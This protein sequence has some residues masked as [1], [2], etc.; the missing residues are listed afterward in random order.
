MTAADQSTLGRPPLVRG[1][2]SLFSLHPPLPVSPCPRLQPRS[3]AS[4][5]YRLRARRVAGY[6]PTMTFPVGLRISMRSAPALAGLVRSRSRRFSRRV[7]GIFL[8]RAWRI[9][10]CAVLNEFE[11]VTGATKE[12]ARLKKIRSFYQRVILRVSSIFSLFRKARRDVTRE[13]LQRRR[14]VKP[15]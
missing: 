13:A 8:L 2:A 7:S 1:L 14:D 5:D 4:P 3:P 10:G 6:I 11:T 12:A 15:H 9:V